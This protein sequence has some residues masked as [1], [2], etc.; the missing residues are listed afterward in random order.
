MKH[1][2][3]VKSKFKKKNSIKKEEQSHLKIKFR[4]NLY[5]NQF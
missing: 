3:K 2:M 1:N 4:S 5:V